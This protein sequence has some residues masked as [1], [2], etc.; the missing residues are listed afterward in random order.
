MKG[1][2]EICK[3]KLKYDDIWDVF[4]VLNYFSMLYFVKELLLK[5]LMLKVFM[6]LLLVIG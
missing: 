6:L 1:V 3:L 5:D 4:K 2:F